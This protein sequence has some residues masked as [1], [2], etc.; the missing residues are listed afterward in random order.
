M[1][2]NNK[3][4]N[5][6]FTALSLRTVAAVPVFLEKRKTK[7]EKNASEGGGGERGFLSGADHIDFLFAYSSYYSNRQQRLPAPFTAP[8][9]ASLALAKRVL[10][11][12]AP[13]GRVPLMGLVLLVLQSLGHAILTPVDADYRAKLSSLCCVVTSSA[14]FISQSTFYAFI[15]INF[16][17]K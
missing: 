7:N 2:D 9:A 16:F 15:E 11:A 1:I 13:R 14:T 5:I 8:L 12:K 3:N 4:K 17:P 6:I 10:H